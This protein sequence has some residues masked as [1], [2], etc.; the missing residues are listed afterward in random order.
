MTVLQDS[1]APQFEGK[2]RRGNPET[3]FMLTV[4]VYITDNFGATSSTNVNVTVHGPWKQ[5]YLLVSV[6][7]VVR[8]GTI[9]FIGIYCIDLVCYPDVF[10]LR[11]VGPS[12]FQEV[13]YPAFTNLSFSLDLQ[14]DCPDHHVSVDWFL[15]R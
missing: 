5:G 1:T 15:Y 12:I 2:L 11:G 3:N 13:E 14:Y 6:F 4:N 10:D 7:L 8:L 9:I